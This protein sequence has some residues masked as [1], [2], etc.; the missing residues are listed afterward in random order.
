MTAVVTSL[1]AVLRNK[2]AMAVWAALILGC[3]LLCLAT[4]LLGV[5]VLIPLLGHAT[6]HGY[7]ET[8][9]AGEWPPA[10]H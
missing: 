1:N 4:G 2:P 3:L 6:W 10:G 9:D 7:R 5:V 8:I